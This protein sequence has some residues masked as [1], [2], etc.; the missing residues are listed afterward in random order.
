MT[1]YL[2]TPVPL[3]TVFGFVS[4]GISLLVALACQVYKLP[5]WQRLSSGIVPL[6]VGIFRCSPVQLVL[7]GTVGEYVGS[8]RTY[9]R[10]LPLVVEK[11]RINFD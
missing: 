3:T 7:L 1:G 10:K 8:I 6:V 5:F 2:E 11:E 9:V 4:D